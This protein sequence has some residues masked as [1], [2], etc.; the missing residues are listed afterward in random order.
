[1][2]AEFDVKVGVSAFRR[3]SEPDVQF[4]VPFPT[5]VY[6]YGAKRDCG[7]EE[8]TQSLAKALQSTRAR[9]LHKGHAHMLRTAM[10]RRD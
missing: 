9:Q 7:R 2:A 4:R 8:D 10:E 6:R 5:F 3:S 1:M